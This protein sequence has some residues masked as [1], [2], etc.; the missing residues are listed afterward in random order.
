MREGSDQTPSEKGSA[1]QCPVDQPLTM[2]CLE[3]G[4]TV[5][6][7]CTF[8]LVYHLPNRMST[9]TQAEST[10][11]KVTTQEEDTPGQQG[12]SLGFSDI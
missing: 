1:P 5:P 12:R 6:L 8:S 3:Q 9:S 2:S 10:T 7:S 4:L 11:A